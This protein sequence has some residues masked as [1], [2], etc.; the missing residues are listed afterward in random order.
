MPNAGSRSRLPN[1]PTVRPNAFSLIELLVVIAVVA[2]LVGLLAPALGGAR[3]AAR[4]VKCSSNQ[5][6]LI[7]AWTMYAGASQDRAMPL[8]YWSSADIAGGGMDGQQVF[9]WGSH[10]TPTSPP[11]FARG[12][13]AP[14]IEGSLRIGSVFECPNQAWGTYR[15]QGPS[16][17]ITSTY[18]YNGYYLSPAKT[19]GWGLTIGHRPWQRLS[20]VE[21]PTRLMVFAD[22]L[23]PSF[24]NALP[25]NT[26]LLDPPL[27]YTGSGSGTGAW[28]PNSSPT[29]SFR[30]GR[31]GSVS[32]GS[33]VAAHADGHVSTIGADPTWLT[34]PAQGIG[35]VN[36]GATNG[37][38]YVPDWERWT[39]P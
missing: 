11:E 12:F 21:Q 28:T 5:R 16:K 26:A 31:R 23:L 6:Q 10:G 8:A 15:P 24:G 20:S 3:E 7:T 35:S 33:T 1:E 18:G 19:P 9:W 25:G 14:Y 37:P 32:I 36:G 29:T 39:G 2:L 27:L 30:H 17:T 4:T 38:S 13:L 22:T 34:S